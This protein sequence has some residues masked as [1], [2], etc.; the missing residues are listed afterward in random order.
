MEKHEGTTRHR[1]MYNGSTIAVNETGHHL[2]S[3]LTIKP[4]HTRQTHFHIIYVP[5]QAHPL[6]DELC[7]ARQAR[8]RPSERPTRVTTTSLSPLSSISQQEEEKEEKRNRVDLTAKR[9]AVYDL[10]WRAAIRR[11]SI[12]IPKE[13]LER[14]KNGGKLSRLGNDNPK[15]NR[16]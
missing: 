12:H 11:N 8:R 9:Q 14:A 1:L 6:K 3:G 4:T 10:L 13:D 16:T 7:A 5:D 2:I 15:H